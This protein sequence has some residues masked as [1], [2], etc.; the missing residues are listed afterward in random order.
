MYE[1]GITVPKIVDALLKN[2]IPDLG[3][4]IPMFVGTYT[5]G[6]V[7]LVAMADAFKAGGDTVSSAVVA[8]NL[9]M[10]IYFFVL[11]AIPSIG[12][13]KKHYSHPIEDELA[14]HEKGEGATNA[15]NYWTP[16]KV[17]LLDV[18]ENFALSF[19]IVAVSDA[20]ANFFASVIPTSNF[21]LTLLN[22]LLGSKYLI[23]TTIT[24]ALATFFHDK[25][26]SIAGAQETGTYL[27]HIFFAVIGVPASIYLIIT[28]APLLLVLAAIIVGTNM[29]V[30]LVF[31]KLL[32]FSIEEIVIASNANIGGPTTAAACA[33]SKEWTVLV[34]PAI[35]VGT[36]GYVIGNYYGIFIGTFLTGL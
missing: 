36:L 22:G 26:G 20:I 27:I 29:V 5:G 19:A 31:G 11:I 17:S 35:L 23:I 4:I 33:I 16:K 32:H 14:K 2:A 9:L 18:A 13:F 15:A 25:V 1:K 34:V 8:D 24:M 21:G 30:S 10:A 3:K 7:N 6:S 28:Q 12:F